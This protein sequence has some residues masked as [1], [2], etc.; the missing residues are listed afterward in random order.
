[1]TVPAGPPGSSVAVV[2]VTRDRAEL[3]TVAVEHLLTLPEQPRVVVVDNASSD[4]TPAV[5]RRRFGAAVDVVA[6]PSNM[7]AA[8]RNVGVRVAGCEAVAFSDDDS[9]WLPG[10]LEAAVRILGGDPMIGLVAGRVQV[11]PSRRADPVSEAMAR[12]PLDASLRPSPAGRRAVMGCLACASVVR[13]RAFL[14]VGGFI[15]GLGIGGEEQLLVL[16]LWAT[17]WKSVY[18]REAVTR[19]FPAEVQRDPRARR[20]TAARNDLWTSWSRLPRRSALRC[21]AEVLTRPGKGTRLGALAAVRRAGWPLAR[22]WSLPPP[23]EK[24]RA[25]LAR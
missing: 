18:A 10:A 24:G 4:G 7:G 20:A 12:G 17:G 8:G 16:D 6:L 15:P 23:V 11:G 22:R 5:L 1:M 13:S 9:W 21:G 25:L 3:V 14:S 19:H 2:V